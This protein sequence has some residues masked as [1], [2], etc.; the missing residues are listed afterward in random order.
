MGEQTPLRQAGNLPVGRGLGWHQVTDTMCPPANG[1]EDKVFTSGWTQS[2][3]YWDF[4]DTD[5]LQLEKSDVY[6]YKMYRYALIATDGQ[7]N[8]SGEMS[9]LT[10]WKPSYGCHK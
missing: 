8:D 7:G 2:G 9:L 5:N 10:L 3:K 6:P 1:S 4:D